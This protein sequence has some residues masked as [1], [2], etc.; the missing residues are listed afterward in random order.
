MREKNWKYSETGMMLLFVL[1]LIMILTTLMVAMLIITSER[2]NMTGMADRRAKA[3]EAAQSG[4]EYA[5]YQLN[6]D[7]N[8]GK[9]VISNITEKLPDG[10]EFS[11]IFDPVETP[12][13][14]NNLTGD[15]KSG[16]TPPF[17]AE[18]ICRGT[19]GRI[20][21]TYRA[22]FKREEEFE[23]PASSA[24]NMNLVTYNNGN[25]SET[26]IK[27]IEP[28]DPGVI[29][30]NEDLTFD[31]DGSGKL[32]LNDGY[33]SSSG[34]VDIT[35]TVNSSQIKIKPSNAEMCYPD[36]DILEIIDDNK[37]SCHTLPSASK[38][39]LFG[40]FEYAQ[41]A[42]CI[43]HSSDLATGTDD[44]TVHTYPYTLG[45]ATFTE[46][47]GIWDYIDVLI[48]FYYASPGTTKSNPPGLPSSP[49]RNLYNSYNP[50]DFAIYGTPE[51]TAIENE[52]AMTVSKTIEPD[53]CVLTTLK[54]T[55]DLYIPYEISI[56]QACSMLYYWS[57][58]HNKY[59]Y[60]PAL[61]ANYSPKFKLDLN[62]H[63]IYAQD[64][65]HIGMPLAGKGNIFSGG[66]I[67]II[68]SYDLEL[69]VYAQ[70]GL[71]LDYC[72]QNAVDEL[73]YRGILYSKSNIGM[74]AL[75]DS[76]LKK[77]NYYG[78]MLSAGTGNDFNIGITSDQVNIFYTHDQLEGICKVRKNFKVRRNECYLLR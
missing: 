24:G 5:F 32:N 8:W 31:G 1:I 33:F 73:T 57:N 10:Q 62:G 11:I 63:N 67:G 66:E 27:G 69:G 21:K 43:P 68:Q 46:S 22:V 2:L 23:L 30:G 54:L 9:G 70:S 71:Y 58:K 51:M 59:S 44:P 56:T 20:S 47:G 40:Y 35:G 49:A 74:Y 50:I 19:Y 75:D 52:L 65:L 45:V 72:S 6:N 13:S 28:N 61:S 76:H 34:N 3:L 25:P 17:S 4:V 12:F 41:N 77:Y 64:S 38:F 48:D 36:I 29:H 14:K 53:G 78:T 42:Y 18:I 60:M 37:A 26:N 7:P 55:S 16:S 39:Y 15:T